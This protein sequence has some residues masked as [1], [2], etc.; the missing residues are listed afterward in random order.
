M[1]GVA[2]G[3]REIK[4]TVMFLKTP[5]S[6][7]DVRKLRAGDVVFL[8]GKLFTARD[9][10][11]KRLLEKPN[12]IP[13]GACVYHCGPLAKKKRKK[14]KLVSAGPTTSSR[15]NSLLPSFIK[16]CSVRAIIGKGGVDA[17]TTA[18]MRGKC[19]YL[20]AVGGAGALYARQLKVK[21]VRWLELGEPEALWELDAR[22][23][24]PLIVAI[25]ERGNNLYLIKRRK[26]A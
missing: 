3:E 6:E 15:M 23:F 12:V 1:L 17:K 25:D 2:Q 14:W 11:T 5:L 13:R 21:S 9:Q 7:N 8:S 20:A 24:G 26:S 18:A 19:V 4:V 10:A 22:S 16:K